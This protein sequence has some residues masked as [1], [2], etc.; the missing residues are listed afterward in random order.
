MKQTKYSWKR[1]S[2]GVQWADVWEWAEDLWRERHLT[3]EVR[4]SPPTGATAT[5]HGSCLVQLSAN[6]PGVGFVPRALKWAAI[7]DPSKGSAASVALRL[8]LDI[9]RE[10]PPSPTER[11]AA[12]RAAADRL[13]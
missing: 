3:V 6:V 5:P 1:V 13:W 8:L 12:D 10:Y 4:L 7:P 2:G 11:E 9:V